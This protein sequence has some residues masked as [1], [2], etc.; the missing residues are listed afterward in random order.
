M[1]HLLISPWLLAPLFGG[2]AL[3]Y[4]SVGLA[5]GSSYIA[6]LTIF[7][8]DYLFI[9][10]VSLSM[11]IMVST[12]GVW[13]FFK[14]RHARLRLILPFLISSIPLA[15]LGGTIHLS[16]QIFHTLLFIFL[17]IVALKIYCFSSFKITAK[18]SQPLAIFLSL[19]IG[20]GLGFISG[21][22]GLGGGIY[23][24]PLI[25]LFGLGNQK[26]A[27]AC[28]TF[29]IWANSVSGLAARIGSQPIPP[30]KILAPL[31]V[32]VAIGGYAGSFFGANRISSQTMQR[33][34]GIIIV[35]ALMFLLPKCF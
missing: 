18:P 13:N 31:L 12:L 17:A 15:W 10:T 34:L 29:F 16:P 22:L 33:I 7:G 19:A 20:A 14:G 23:L 6:L 9:P 27:A 4:S 30:F 11:N 3:L 25:V 8:I 26:E 21:A 5:G 35:I 2:V 24:I 28:G 32:S 1:E